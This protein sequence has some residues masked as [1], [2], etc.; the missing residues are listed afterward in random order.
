MEN[1][2]GPQHQLQHQTA[3]YVLMKSEPLYE[4]IPA[5]TAAATTAAAAASS[6]LSSALADVRSVY[7]DC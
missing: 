5:A 2:G 6:S 4:T 1:P 3:N 7:Y